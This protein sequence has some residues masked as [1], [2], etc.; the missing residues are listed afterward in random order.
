[1]FRSERRE[2]METVFTSVQSL[3][4]HDLAFRQQKVYIPRYQWPLA[5]SLAML[6]A[7]LWS[8]RAG[9][10]GSPAGGG[11]RR[12]AVESGAVRC[13]CR[14]TRRAR[15]DQAPRALR[16]GAESGLEFNK[17]TAAV[18]GR[19]VVPGGAGLPTVDQRTRRPAIPSAW[20]ISRTPTTT[21]AIRLYRAGEKTASP[22]RRT[23]WKNGRSRQGLR[24]GAAAAS[25]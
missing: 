2:G 4:K 6:L 21:L 18:P 15:R 11:E 10:G 8:D 23:R 19:P 3:A 7:S 5:A 20:P 12:R 22:R 1:M 9:G 16:H 24:D 25:R 17:G 14:P 13:S